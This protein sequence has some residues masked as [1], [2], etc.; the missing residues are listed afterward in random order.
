M[1]TIRLSKNLAFTGKKK[2]INGEAFYQIRCIDLLYIHMM[3]GHF[4][5]VPVGSIGG[6]VG[7]N[8]II[9]DSWVRDDSTVIN[10]VI[11]NTMIKNSMVKNTVADFSSLYKCNVDNTT[12]LHSNL[13]YALLNN[14]AVYHSYTNLNRLPIRNTTIENSCIQGY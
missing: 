11:E 4:M 14:V 1:K 3:D 5:S 10:S 8:T 6:F 9:R 12:I 7:R 13:S 2:I